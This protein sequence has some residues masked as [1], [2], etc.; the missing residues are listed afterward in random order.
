MLQLE[1]EVLYDSIISFSFL[2]ADNKL[3]VSVLL[4]FVSVA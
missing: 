2:L 4:A 1:F 3:T